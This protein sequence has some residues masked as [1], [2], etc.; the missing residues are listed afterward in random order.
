MTSASADLL[1]IPPALDRALALT[2][3]DDARA[4]PARAATA[5][6]DLDLDAVPAPLAAALACVVDA[7]AAQGA[8]ASE[9]L[10]AV[11]D[12]FAA[13]VAGQAHPAGRARV[14][15]LDG[16]ARQFVAARL[17][18]GPARSATLEVN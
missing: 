8:R 6:V 16:Q 4:R 11:E 18:Y 14:R 2:V 1:G 7:L 15:A 10:L 12:A 13:L 5:D 17:G 9:V 3:L